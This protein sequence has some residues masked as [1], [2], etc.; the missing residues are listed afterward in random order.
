MKA[1]GRMKKKSFFSGPFFCTRRTL[2]IV[3]LSFLAFLYRLPAGFSDSENTFDQSLLAEVQS[4]QKL[5]E[6]DPEAYQKKIQERRHRVEKD[7]SQWK[8]KR[9][10][11]F[12]RFMKRKDERLSQHEVFLKK[13]NPK[14]Y[15]QFRAKRL[16]H[17]QAQQ[18][19][20][21][22]RP[23]ARIDASR[24]PQS[25]HLAPESTAK[26]PPERS[27]KSAE[28]QRPKPFSAREHR[29]SQAKDGPM[30][31]L[32]N[33]FKP[34]ASDS[35]GTHHPQLHREDRRP[36]GANDT[37][38]PRTHR[39]SENNQHLKQRPVQNSTRPDHKNHPGPRMQRQRS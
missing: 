14:L 6:A 12:Q 11:V 33:N 36:F 5:K 24:Q 37:H 17:F 23:Q 34:S 30:G 31:T 35:H 19:S 10:E 15:Q 39:P 8:E 2:L 16:E 27:F 26:R 28:G 9:P 7:L 1:Q 32:D 29:D 13:N 3:T 18:G 20:H 25:I 22:E 4:L 21:R 38:F